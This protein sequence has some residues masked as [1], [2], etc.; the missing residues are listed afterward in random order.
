MSEILLAAQNVTKQFPGVLANDDVS[1]RLRPGRILALLGENGAGKST[2]V[3]VLFGMYRPDSGQVVIKD[4]AVDLHGPDDAISRGI[5]MV[6]QHFQLVPPMRVVENIVLGDEPTKRGLVDLDEARKRV[7]EL[8]GR[9]GLEI[10]PDALVEDLPVGMQQRVEILKALYRNADVLIL[11]EPT[12]VLTPQEADHLL[13]VLRELTETGLGIVFITHKLREVLAI[14]D[15]IVVL[16]NGQVVGETTPSQTSESGLAEMMVGRSVVLQVEKS[17]ADPGDVVLKVNELEVNDD[18]GQIALDGLNFEVRAGE[19]L[20]VAGVEGNGQRELV[21]AI[22]GLRNPSVGVMEIDGEELTSGSPRQI[23]KKGVAHIPEDREKHG[24][25]AVYSVAENSVLNR[26][27]RK[28]FSIRGILRRDV[29]RGHAQD[30]VDEFDVRTPNVLVPASSLSGGNK[31]KLIVGREFSDEIKL[32][33]AAQPTR[34]IDIG[35]IEFIHRRILEQRDKGTA[36]LLV[37][38]ELDEILGLSDR[39]AV[40]YDGKIM[41]VID[42]QDADREKIGLLMAGITD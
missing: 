28:P 36:V 41:D 9:Y 13:G 29:I 33:V 21:E 15:D 20:G 11:D 2:L 38:A 40:L 37:S 24:V 27:H 8:S 31:Q 6:H 18:R 16:R 1:I 19:I 5:G 14:A 30:V 10:D 12:G 35:A 22:T 34:G 23:T 25:V 7:V 3:N 17:T 26:Y 39:I 32:L 4:E 42:A